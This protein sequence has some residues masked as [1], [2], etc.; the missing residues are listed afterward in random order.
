VRLD[1]ANPRGAVREVEEV[2]ARVRDAD[3]V[4][5]GGGGVRS[6]S[7][8]RKIKRQAYWTYIQLGAGQK[9]SENAPIECEF[10]RE[11]K[12]HQRHES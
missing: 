11:Q 6:D 12:P 3:A 8:A 1:N 5:G 2:R 7:G 4:P 9:A 10:A